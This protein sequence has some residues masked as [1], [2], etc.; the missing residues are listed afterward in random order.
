MKMRATFLLKF[1]ETTA[2]AMSPQ[3]A[4]AIVQAIDAIAFALQANHELN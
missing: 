2:G 4:A 1:K 3:G